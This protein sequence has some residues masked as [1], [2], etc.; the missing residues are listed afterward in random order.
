MK[1]I[2]HFWK[3]FGGEGFKDFGAERPSR[4]LIPTIYNAGGGYKYT[5]VDG[6]GYGDGDLSLIK[7]GVDPNMNSSNEN[8]FPF[9]LIQYFF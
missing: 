4:G 2:A 3:V 8:R 6:S 7:Y 5:F 9:E 1:N